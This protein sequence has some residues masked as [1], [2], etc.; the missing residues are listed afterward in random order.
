MRTDR[1]R[2]SEILENTPDIKQA[3]KTGK[4]SKATKQ[5]AKLALEDKQTIKFHEFP[6]QAQNKLIKESPEAMKR[7]LA[8][9]GFGAQQAEAFVAYSPKTRS[10]ISGL[11]DEAAISLLNQGLD[12]NLL[13]ATLTEQNLKASDPSKVPT[14]VK[15]A[16][17]DQAALALGEKLM[18][19]GNANVMEELKSQ[20][21]GTLSEES[22]KVAETADLLLKDYQ[23]T[24][25]TGTGLALLEGA[26]C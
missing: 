17:S 11:S 19:S 1:P 15:P 25:T 6:E 20:S 16:S 5:L 3:R 24:G 9:E 18:N 21:N 10:Q 23:L 12:E 26:R 22:I 13:A 2:T 7:M 8:M 14:T 4:V